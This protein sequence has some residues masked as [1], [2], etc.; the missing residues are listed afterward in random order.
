MKSDI[1]VHEI[2]LGVLFALFGLTQLQLLNQSTI[3]GLDLL[4]SVHTF[5]SGGHTATISWAMIGAIAI[6]AI[7]M[8][9]N[10]WTPSLTAG[11]DIW[12]II[13]TV[14]LILAPPFVPILESVLT[15]SMLPGIIAFTIQMIGY[16]SASYLQ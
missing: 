6:L 13:V 5:S 12:I 16:G 8:W 11:I 4:G 10:D 2:V 15:D 9:T 7:T 1:D 14:W 3:L